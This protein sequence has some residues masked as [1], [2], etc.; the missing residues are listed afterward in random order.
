MAQR[1]GSV[2]VLAAVTALVLFSGQEV[3]ADQD[4]RS[5]EVADRLEELEEDGV[6]SVRIEAPAGG[7]K[8]R[9]A[10]RCAAT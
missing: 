10:C 5:E 2:A 3:A 1:L 6:L 9:S 8:T 4:K 7:G